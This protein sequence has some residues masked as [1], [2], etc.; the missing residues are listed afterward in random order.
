MNKMHA[1]FVAKSTLLHAFLCVESESHL[2]TFSIL[3]VNYNY[4]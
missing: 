4:R 3:Q 2:N 1:V